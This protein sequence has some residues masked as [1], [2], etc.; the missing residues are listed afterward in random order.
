MLGRD[1]SPESAARTEVSPPSSTLQLGTPAAFFCSQSTCRRSERSQTIRTL[2]S[3]HQDTLE[4]HWEADSC[5][6]PEAGPSSLLAC[7][8]GVSLRGQ[9]AGFSQSQETSGPTLIL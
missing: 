7:P 4:L 5:G 9:R 3:V 8:H 2:S 1:Q 6:P